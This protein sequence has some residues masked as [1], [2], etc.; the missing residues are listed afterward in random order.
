MDA[1]FET[2]ACNLHVFSFSADGKY[3]AIIFKASARVFLYDMSSGVA[4]QRAVLDAGGAEVALGSAA[5]TATALDW[6][7][8]LCQFTTQGTLMVCD[9]LDGVIREF[10]MNAQLIG[11]VFITTDVR[12]RLV[13]PA[14]VQTFDLC[15]P[16]SHQTSQ[17]D[18]S[19]DMLA[20]NFDD[21]MVTQL[22][23][24]TGVLTKIPVPFQGGG[25]MRKFAYTPDGQGIMVFTS[26]RAVQLLDLRGNFIKLLCE[27]KPAV[28][29]DGFF[30]HTNRLER[31]QFAFEQ[32]DLLITSVHDMKHGV[33]VGFW[34]NPRYPSA[35]YAHG[36]L[37][38]L[39][40]THCIIYE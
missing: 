26:T 23:K 2:M 37:C 32:P 4:K 31:I 24:S 3:M 28:H 18:M 35:S 36:K 25:E 39:C 20:V 11:V 22:C 34:K 33:A 10:D 27:P 40:A 12:N 9:W 7:P 29:Y 8:C 19:K 38:V 15:L 17:L 21:Y 30:T 13:T 5:V 1:S 14:H 6:T 16:T